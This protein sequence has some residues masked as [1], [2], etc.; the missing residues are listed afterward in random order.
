[1]NNKTHYEVPSVEVVFFSAEDIISTSG[2]DL[3]DY[4]FQEM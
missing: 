3:P 1:M 2:I 4:E